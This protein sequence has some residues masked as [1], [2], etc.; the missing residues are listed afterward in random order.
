MGI[1]GKAK[2]RPCNKTTDTGHGYIR[3][4][5]VKRTG[6]AKLHKD[7]VVLPVSVVKRL[8]KLMTK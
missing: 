2:P 8:H 4:G 7:E 6:S 3:G 5:R 1:S